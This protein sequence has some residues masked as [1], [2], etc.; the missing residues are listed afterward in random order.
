MRFLLLSLFLAALA[1]DVTAQCAADTCMNG[2]VCV[3]VIGAASCACPAGYTGLRCQNVRPTA[4]VCPA[5][6]STKTTMGC[7]MK[8]V[9][10]MIEYARGDSQSDVD[11]EG[12]FIKDLISI[13]KL[14]NQNVRVGIVT[15]HDTVQDVIHIDQ[16]ANDPYGLTLA[17]TNLTRQLQP[18]GE[19]DLG[20]ALDFVR[21]NAFTGS[22]RGAEKIVV[23]IVHMM[24]QRTKDK[25]LPAANALKDDCVTIVGMGVRGNR[26]FGSQSTLDEQLMAQVV[27]SPPEDHYDRY[28]SFANLETGY[29]KYDDVNCP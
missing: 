4:A 12:D 24:P 6:T 20:L 21:T 5:V 13:W 26:F 23:P 16:F 15:Y 2:G 25:I 10:F 28:S 18:S 11:H 29:A 19:N 9:V 27:T 8:E 22:R 7:G 3:I 17:I 14:G 1:Y